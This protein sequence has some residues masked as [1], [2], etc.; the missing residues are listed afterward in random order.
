MSVES[1]GSGATPNP[2]LGAVGPKPPVAEQPMPNI[3]AQRV[4]PTQGTSAGSFQ[5][6]NSANLSSRYRS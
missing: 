6:E 4:L 1:I 3:E 5:S 2:T